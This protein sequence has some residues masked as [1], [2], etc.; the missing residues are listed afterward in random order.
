MSL[1]WENDEDLAGTGR[2]V[3]LPK[4]GEEK[5]YEIKEV[6]KV[7]SGQDRFHIKRREKI[8]LPD[9][10]EGVVETSLGFH[11]ECDLEDDKIL[12]ITSLSPFIS[13][14]QE[15]VNDGDKLKVSHPEKG[16]WSF[17]VL[18]RPKEAG[19]GPN[20]KELLGDEEPPA[21]EA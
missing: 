13:F 5:T 21:E 3:Y 16:V 12:S 1:D 14:K 9:G 4:V 6:R 20:I 19:A 8:D 11:I 17:E 15:K 7:T 10:T 2:F 18:N